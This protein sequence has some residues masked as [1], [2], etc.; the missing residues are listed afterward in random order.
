MPRNPAVRAAFFVSG[1][2]INPHTRVAI[3]TEAHREFG[4][5]AHIG[6]D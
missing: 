3:V 5:V 2:T 6:S 4:G 1:V